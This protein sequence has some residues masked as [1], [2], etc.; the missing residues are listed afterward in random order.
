M[1]NPNTQSFPP[2][3][4]RP[5]FLDEVLE[6]VIDHPLCKANQ[7]DRLAVVLP[8]HRAMSKL[9]HGLMGRLTGPARL[10]QFYALSGFVEASSPWTAAD[11]L[12]VL[13]RLHRVVGA[14]E[15]V[16]PFDRFVPWAKVVLDDFAAVDHELAEVGKVFQNLADI[17]GIEDWSFGEETWSEDQK[18]FERQWRRLPE[19]YAQLHASLGQNGLATRAH[20]TRRLA[21]GEGYLD[22]DHVL[23]AGLATMSTAEWK[24]LSAWE[25]SNKLTVLWDAD[26]TYVDDV[27]NEAGLFIRKFKSPKTPLPKGTLATQPPKVSVVGCASTVLQTQHVRDI[28]ANLTPEQFN[29]TLVVLP[30][31]GTLGTLLQALP[32]SANGLNVTMGLAMHET[33]VLS[34]V[35]QVFNMLETTTD[36]WRLEQLQ[37][38]HAHPVMHHI[39]RVQGNSTGAGRAMHSLAKSHR[40]WVNADDFDELGARG[41]AQ[42]VRRLSSLRE[43]ESSRFLEALSDWARDMESRLEAMPTEVSSSDNAELPSSAVPWIPV[44]WRRFRTVVAVLQ[45]L[46]STHSPMSTAAEVRAMARRMLR[47]E[48]VDLLGEPNRGLQVMGLTETRA[49]DFDRVIVLDMNEGTVPQT[50][51]SDSFLPL[52]L[53]SSLGM[54][55][56]REREARYAYLV[57]R[58]LNRAS[59]VHLL[60]RSSPD[61]KEGGEPSRYLMQLEGSFHKPDGN[62]HLN[63]EHVTLHVPLPDV[64]P[65]IRPMTMTDAM[66]DRLKTWSSEGMSPSA[67][68]TMLQCPRNFAYRYLYGMG[69]ATELQTSMEASTLGSVVHHVMEHGLEQAQG[70]ILTT[71]HLDDVANALDHH[72]AN[73][74][75]SEYN[76]S[77][78]K[79]GENVLQ[80]EIARTTLK[81]FLRQEKAE[82]MAGQPAPFIQ[83]REKKLSSRHPG[84]TFGTLAFAGTADRLER[85]AD[86]PRV[87]DY[88]TGKVEAKEL[89]LKGDWTA[90]L[91]GGQKGKALQLVVYAAMVLATMDEKAQ[92]SGVTA[93]IRSGR[94]VKAGLL[95]LNIDGESLI[96]PQH[97]DTLIAWLADTLDRFAAEG[98]VLEHA[99]DAKYCEHCVVLDPP[100]SSSY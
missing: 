96:R 72:L 88:K 68:N 99:S 37:A 91:E 8:S 14:S 43:I 73:A 54:P 59:E 34:F 23:A 12:E 44:G 30:D 53:R 26:P 97:V 95:A 48:R 40:A 100:A 98:Q 24:C 87:L 55:G 5:S 6:A 76:A 15:D 65:A 84:T 61:R 10:P 67:L 45:R 33:P 46:Q 20:L 19:L 85:V 69:E 92:A 57:H 63:V 62:P 80:L 13:V 36:T 66:R 38:F 56:P 29:Q 75:Q 22:V 93:A 39:H 78:V 64:R 51:R 83:D 21:E 17:Q 77:L 35:D 18:A 74:L 90:E 42:D 25:K 2:T 32:S 71:A 4:S 79:R 58:L 7:L 16:L 86:I 47:Q 60:Y 28:L 41:F 52:D 94:N 81:K 89:K 11:P 3:L 49:L 9:R 70:H 50:S 1:S 27:H 82:L 31:G